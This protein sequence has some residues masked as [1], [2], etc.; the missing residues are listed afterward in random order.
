M[1]EVEALSKSF[2]FG[3]KALDGISFT[4]RPG[5]VLGFLGPNGAGK[6]TTM[7]I[8]SG[9]LR[10]TG[11]RA[12]VC[13]CD[14]ALDSLGARR[15]LGY[16]PEQVPLYGEMRVREY[17][18]FRAD[19]RGLPTRERKTAIAAVLDEVGLAGESERIIGQLSKGYRQRVG[20]AD[21]LLHRPAA[22]ILDEPTDGLDP[23]QRREVL[24]LITRL[25]RDRTVVLSTHV[26]PEVE[27]VCER[28][29]IVDRGKVVASGTTAELIAGR[30]AP[31]LADDHRGA[32]RFAIEI[33]CRGD[34]AALL[35]AL[36]AVPGVASVE[37]D[38]D[39]DGPDR[40]H[41]PDGAI[42]FLVQL[43]PDAGPDPTGAACEA[44][45]RAVL[46]HGELRLLTP[47]RSSL[48]AV[49]RRLTA[50]PANATKGALP[51]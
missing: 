25:S 45:S 43:H 26:L 3:T 4:A 32:S 27:T 16:L 40:K 14:V 10:P 5:G 21:A 2:S 28:V 22:L 1:I 44:L 33:A 18:R 8:L 13:G 42:H 51:R 9:Y 15:Q 29:V 38:N 37:E 49:F 30:V 39:P 24:D 47:A 34:R 35:A 20:L 19:L 46:T 12:R 50:A 17:L 23:N 7:R 36:S 41:A 48:E 11:G 31:R 6:T